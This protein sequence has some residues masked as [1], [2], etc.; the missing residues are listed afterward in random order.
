MQRK[1][2]IHLIISQ[3]YAIHLYIYMEQEEKI[4]DLSHSPRQ[5]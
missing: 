2:I 1:Q 5:I 4:K 3:C